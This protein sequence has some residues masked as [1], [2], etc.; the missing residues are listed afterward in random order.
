MHIVMLIIGVLGGAAALWWR[1]KS[2]GEAGRDAADMAGRVRGAYRRGK[3]R[4]QAEGSVLTTVDDPALAAA[5]FLFALA[6]ERAPG[7]QPATALVRAELDDIIPA[8]EMDEKIAYAEWAA[9][10]VADPRDCIRRFS[11]L[12]R[13]ALSADERDHLFD[14]ATNITGP[15]PEPHQQL[16]LDALRTAIT[17]KQGRA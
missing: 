5:I 17:D 14:M 4:K 3:F 8:S 10:S 9:R 13:S 11:D 7:T 2:I 12:W 15:S 16:C 1:F 6:G